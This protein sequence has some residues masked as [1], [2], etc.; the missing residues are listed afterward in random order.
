[1]H[2]QSLVRPV[3][4]LG[5]LALM[6][7]GTTPVV[8]APV[9]ITA[10]SVVDAPGEYVVT[11]DLSATDVDQ[12]I[13]V[14]SSNV[15][16]DGD[17]HTIT[18][19][20]TY[21]G[22]VVSPGV[23][24]VTIRNLT[25]EGFEDE[26]LLV[27]EASNVQVRA[28]TTRANDVGVRVYNSADVRLE[29]ITLN[30][31]RYTGIEAE[32]STDVHVSGLTT[33]RYNDV[34]FDTY[35][36]DFYGANGSIR[37]AV[38]TPGEYGVAL[39]LDGSPGTVVENVT[40]SA[41]EDIA[42]EVD[43]S[44][45]LVVR[46]SHFSGGEYED[47][48]E[49][50]GSPDTQLLNNTFEGGEYGLYLSSSENLTLRNNVIN[51][52]EWGLF[53]AGAHRHDI[54]TSNTVDGL[55]VYY[56]VGVQDETITAL[57]G[58]YFGVVDGSNV[59][60]SGITIHGRGQG[61]VAAHVDG[62]TVED[63]EFGGNKHGLTISDSTAV[64]V[65]DVNV[66]E[67]TRGVNLVDS[68]DVRI[69]RLYA[70]TSGSGSAV[71]LANS[72][73]VTV[74]D[75][76]FDR[77]GV[78]ASSGSDRLVVRD[79]AFT[80][81][82]VV[83]FRSHDLHVTN[84]TFAVGSV[85]V[86]DFSDRAVIANNTFA[87][88]P[89][90]VALGSHSDEAVVRDN[91]FTNIGRDFS[92]LDGIAIGLHSVTDTRVIRN[93]ITD[94]D[95]YGVS[96][97]QSQRTT[98]EANTF[99]D[100]RQ[101]VAIHYGTASDSRHFV[102]RTNVITG[103]RD[104]ILL[105]EYAHDAVIENNTISS[106][107]ENGVF[108]PSTPYSRKSTNVTIADNRI[109]SAGTYGI[110]LN[111]P[112]GYVIDN[113]TLVG[114]APALGVVV[115]GGDQVAIRDN[116]VSGYTGLNFVD[117]EGAIALLGVTN[118]TVTE[119]EVDHSYTGIQV[120]VLDG[121][122]TVSRNRVLNATVDGIAV[123]SG[124]GTVT[125]NVV[126]WSDGSGIRAL[127]SSSTGPLTVA[128]N[129]L[130]GNDLG[131]E[132]GDSGVV[133]RN[134]TVAANGVGIELVGGGGSGGLPTRVVDN[135][136]TGSFNGSGLMASRADGGTFENNTL[137][138]NRFGISLLSAQ[139]LTVTNNSVD[140]ST[141]GLW[142]GRSLS[143]IQQTP[144][145]GYRYS[146]FPETADNVVA[147]NRFT[148]VDEGVQV[149][150]FP[151]SIT[152]T[153]RGLTISTN[154]RIGTDGITARITISDS[155]EQIV[156][157]IADGPS[158]INNTV[159]DNVFDAETP[160]VEVHGVEASL[161]PRY[162]PALAP[163]NWSVA[164]QPGPNA[165]GGPFIGGNYWG[166]PNGT[167]VS[168]ACEDGSGD[169]FCDVPY[170]LTANNTDEL[171][172]TTPPTTTSPD[173][174]VTPTT[175]DFGS[176]VVGNSSARTLTVENLG[177]APLSVTATSV[178]GANASHFTVTNGGAFTL[179][180]AENRTL[181][182]VY[183]PTTNGTHD[184]TVTV[185]SND[186]DEP[187]VEVALG[188]TGSTA[189]APTPTTPTVPSVEIVDVLGS[190]ETD[191]TVWANDTVT[192]TVDAADAT[193]AISGVE[194]KFDSTVAPFVVESTATYDAA[195]GHW[196]ATLD[197]RGSLP[198]DGRYTISARARNTAGVAEST[199]ANQTLVV[200]RTR[201]SLGAT[202]ARVSASTA[203]VSVTAS[204]SLR[205]GSIAVTVTDESGTVVTPSLTRVG[206]KW[207][208]TFPVAGDGT[209]NISAT[210]LDHAGNRGTDT[211][212]TR[213][214]TL[215]TT[216][217]TATVVLEPSGTFIRFNTSSDV[218]DSLVVAD[219]Q[220]PLAPL[221][222]DRSGVHFIDAELGTTLNATLTNA[223]IGVPVDSAALPAGVGVDDVNVS[224]YDDVAGSWEELPT[225]VKSVSIGG[226][227]GQY[228]VTEVEHFSTY[229][230]VV[231]DTTS[232]TLVAA[233]P[234]G[235]LAPDTKETQVRFEYADSGSGVDVGTVS[236]VFDG[237][238]VNDSALS[239]T[240]DSATYDASGLSAG[241]YTASVTL[242]DRAGNTETFDLS[243]TVPSATTEEDSGTDPDPDPDTDSGGDSE[244][245]NDGDAG[246]SDRSSGDDRSANDEPVPPA[247]A[248]TLDAWGRSNVSVVGAKAN[249]P[250]SVDTPG[251]NTSTF[252]L[253]GV[254]VTV[255]VDGD[256]TL[257]VGVN[258]SAPS[259]APTDPPVHG[260]PIAYLSIDHSV[261]DEDIGEV[262]FR[263]RVSKA[264]L[265]ERGVTAA[266]VVI[267]RYHDGT[268]QPAVTTTVG[269]TDD[270][271]V[272][273]ATVPGL[274][275][276]AVGVT[277]SAAVQATETE[278]TEAEATESGTQS[279]G[280]ESPR[281]TPSS[282]PTPGVQQ[283]GSPTLPV[284]LILIALLVISVGVLVFR[285]RGQPPRGP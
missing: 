246:Q 269:E 149:V 111:D 90:G 65:R 98:I 71:H 96:M 55:P 219:S 175:V 204:E 207:T 167:G 222:A 109:T 14:A 46:D 129:R 60:F 61:L 201:P 261:P 150:L 183:A 11:A 268:W 240:R 32:D 257:T 238:S 120:T 45:G 75:G 250:V 264:M 267:Y 161:Q 163:N 80:E 78:R 184:A 248:V 131:I 217:G 186:P 166:T 160:F 25:I 10:C 57:D 64:V 230:T 102:V 282:S 27:D 156:S 152:T 199:V 40:A 237:K 192:V 164:S 97:S 115:D 89:S 143:Q 144:E 185:S 87:D 208:G 9:S 118:A 177:T 37:D 180:P 20:D 56:F 241:T 278:T 108:L 18:G 172:L 233:S 69:E 35:V 140:N 249:Q 19:T 170:E 4:L 277:D 182:V 275:V 130:L 23:S 245:T 135:L 279:S 94:A 21:S 49:I 73:D 159:Y 284:A 190:N 188:G 68:A 281:A 103:G 107:S 114:S 93:E 22:I 244:P 126:Q 28:L 16:I 242:S 85:D 110:I 13:L 239:V 58:G 243:F 189:S 141:W 67:S 227:S 154:F 124:T 162:D 147:H 270:Q 7:A 145:G 50:F 231:V 62:L 174:D 63:S 86:N 70:E 84:N 214:V 168:Q 191:A 76:T 265:A 41:T 44:P 187:S 91:T 132:V 280:T 54:D 104:G 17:G 255:A 247:V 263:Y 212:T 259:G 273:E 139:G 236:F 200:D 195:S 31:D 112:V 77:M 205:P 43:D 234:S 220:S 30:Y 228:W 274:S 116:E 122:S 224:Y 81:A 134:N 171:P 197:T 165:V 173:V 283:Q 5:L 260:A 202:S 176:V 8:A 142:M 15:V 3:V 2:S 138:D 251:Q 235:T 52:S 100:A 254:N 47:T 74:I 178:G 179:E 258:A 53:I 113:N 24:N 101:A 137:R 285:Y 276:F 82:S 229:G 66:S 128:D 206:E 157:D 216:N 151:D 39:Q 59:T 79:T 210:A 221:T 72:T 211:A 36:V 153:D 48:A 26:G 121:N 272:L 133:V 127:G 158:V 193:S 136:V 83:T 223:T 203:R 29:S 95:M 105:D 92:N 226:V 196:V 181:T 262:R 123:D 271:Y 198:D 213:F 215:S 155:D 34:G 6:L 51:G 232:P 252:V 119:N 256:F 1:M 266:D 225:V 209:Y 106:V 125:D 99:T 169:G 117:R 146:W 38:L 12:C 42:F 253:D 194:V 148:A 33:T 218:T 88:G